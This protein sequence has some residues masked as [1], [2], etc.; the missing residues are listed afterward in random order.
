M[1]KQPCL[2]KVY[3]EGTVQINTRCTKVSSA[4]D[5]SPRDIN[6]V[7]DEICTAVLTNGIH[8]LEHANR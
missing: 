3:T 4:I 2:H 7:C 8:V 1:L 6:L 5:R